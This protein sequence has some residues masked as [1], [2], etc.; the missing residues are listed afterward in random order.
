MKVLVVGGGGREH[1]IAWKIAQSPLAERVFVAPGNAGTQEE[2]S[3]R[4]IDLAADDTAGLLAFARE[5]AVDLVVIGPEAPLAAGLADRF[6]DASVAVFGPSADAARLESSKGYCKDFLARHGIP[7]ARYHRTDSLEDARA[8]LADYPLPVVVKADGL[9]AGKGVVIARSAQEAEQACLAM[10][11]EGRMG[12]A[13]RSVVIEEFLPGEE[14]S[15]I[16]MVDGADILPL[17]SSRDHKARDEGGAGPNTGGMGACSPAPGF[18]AELEQTVLDSIIRPTV[19]G[20]AR[21][22]V[23][24]RGFLYAG[25]MV[26]DDGQPR[27]LE[28]NCRMGDPETQ[29]ILAR[30]RSDFLAACHAGA[31]GTL[32]AVTLDWDPRPALG[33]VLAVRDYPADYP[34]GAAIEGLDEVA[35]DT[36]V[37]VFHAGTRR[38]AGKIVTSGGRVL[39]VVGCGDD[40][41]DAR[42]RAYRACGAI[43]FEGCFSRSDIGAG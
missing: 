22:G 19:E 2:P 15:Y 5:K 6:A 3:V 38:A 27:V 18:D 32:G 35:A 20:L 23:H 30:M 25:L 13:G 9:A 10:L 40:L 11:Q 31:T 21:E 33:V 29:P 24:Y 16:C 43:C 26:G 37:K 41:A 39:C 8:I 36:D 14:A 1:A 28:Y 4:N 17:A 7:T 42:A 34:K 12:A